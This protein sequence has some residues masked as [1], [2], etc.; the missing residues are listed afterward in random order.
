M[1]NEEWI[2]RFQSEMTAAESARQAG[3]EGM[4]RVCARRAVGIIVAEYFRRNNLPIPDTSAYELIKTLRASPGIS[5]HIQEIAGHF[6]VRITPDRQLPV[7]A[8]LIQEAYWLAQ[9]L[10]EPL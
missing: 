4:A 2:G 3:N 5:N 6:L 10:L 7:E 8:D 9:Q 1:N